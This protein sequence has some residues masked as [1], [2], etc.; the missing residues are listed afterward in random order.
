MRNKLTYLCLPLAAF[1]SMCSQPKEENII[2]PTDTKK[3]TSEGGLKIDSVTRKV[4]I[5]TFYIDENEVSSS[6]YK[7]YKP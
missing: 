3:A 2:T 6:K 5:D 1:L 4:S 7:E